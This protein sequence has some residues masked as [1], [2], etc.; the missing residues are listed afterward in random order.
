MATG[1]GGLS[2]GLRSLDAQDNLGQCSE[3]AFVLRPFL[4]STATY[5]PWLVA[6][7]SSMFKASG[8]ASS[9]LSP[10]PPPTITSP[11]LILTL[12]SLSRGP[13]N[14]IRPPGWP[15]VIS[16]SNNEQQPLTCLAAKAL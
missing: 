7:P 9:N 16:S 4:S 12:L 14:Y 5:I 1:P 6:H 11:F 15:R 10:P 13:C 3:G 8:V 2:S